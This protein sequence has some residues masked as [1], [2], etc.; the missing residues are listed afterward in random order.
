MLPA[1]DLLEPVSCLASLLGAWLVGSVGRRARW[2]G[3]IAFLAA[4]VLLGAWAGGSGHWWWLAMYVGFV[5]TSIRGILRDSGRRGIQD[6]EVVENLLPFSNH[7]PPIHRQNQGVSDVQT[8]LRN[9][10]LP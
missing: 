3:W 4:N 5:V 10:P 6:A 7:H 9:H 2:W 1:T 8:H